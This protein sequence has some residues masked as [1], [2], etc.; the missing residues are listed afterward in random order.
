MPVVQREDGAGIAWQSDG[1]DDAPAVLLIMGLAYPA[2]MWFRLV[3]GLAERY[4]VLRLDNRGAGLTGD[5]PGA[6]YTVATMAGDCLA[7]LDAAGAQKAHLVG[8]SM[9]GLMAQEIAVTAPD[10]VRSLCLTA[11]HPGIAHAVVDP[12]AMAM[13]MKRGEM[14]PAQAAEASVPYNY[15]PSTP[16]ERIEEDWAV[17]FPLAASNEGYLAQAVGSSQWDGYDRLPDITAPT[18]VLH[19]EGDRLVPLDNGRTLAERIPGAELV[20]V[21]EAN[22]VLMT[23]QPEQV[24]KILLDWLDRNS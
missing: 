6:P 3:P 19:G 20:V 16:R 14:T 4:R 15:A 24:G 9:G 1:P 22:H 7:V 23:D 10:R 12:E 21:P 13:L 18:L 17:R 8:I 5:V 11:T 2:A